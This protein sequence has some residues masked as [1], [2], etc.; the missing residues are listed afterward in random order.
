MFVNHLIPWPP[1]PLVY[2]AVYY[3]EQEHVHR[4][5]DRPTDRVHPS[6]MILIVTCTHATTLVCGC[7]QW[8]EAKF[9][10][11]HVGGVIIDNWNYIKI[12]ILELHH[13]AG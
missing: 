9:T 5:T 3:C 11:I 6:H 10:T 2:S 8:G 7:E 1:F 13:C 4:P 12:I